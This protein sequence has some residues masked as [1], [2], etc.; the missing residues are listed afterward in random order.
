MAAPIRVPISHVVTWFE[1]N[2]RIPFL[3]FVGGVLNGRS[4]F[5]YSALTLQR[6]S[7]NERIGRNTLD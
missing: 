5:L 4:V 7:N 6:Y 2:V 3:V 1:G